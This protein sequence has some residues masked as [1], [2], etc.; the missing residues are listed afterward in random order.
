MN[1]V[2]TVEEYLEIDELVKTTEAIVR[3]IKKD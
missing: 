2:H 3:Y 1:N